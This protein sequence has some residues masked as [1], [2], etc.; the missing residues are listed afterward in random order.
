MRLATRRYADDERN[1]IAPCVERGHCR[2]DDSFVSIQLL[3][4]RQPCS[5]ITGRVTAQIASMSNI[6]E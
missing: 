2:S 1:G 6:N 3:H 5:G 4:I